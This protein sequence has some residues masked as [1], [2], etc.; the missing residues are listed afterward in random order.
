MLVAIKYCVPFTEVYSLWTR[1][2]ATIYK[3]GMN[4]M[5][6]LASLFVVVAG[7][8]CGQTVPPAPPNRAPDSVPKGASATVSTL[9]ASSQAPDLTFKPNPQDAPAPAPPAVETPP[10]APAAVPDAAETE[11]KPAADASSDKN[12]GNNSTPVTTQ[13]PKLVDM[14]P[15]VF[16][17]ND[18]ISV[19]VYNDNIVSGTYP[20][21]PD[22]RISMPLIH[23]FTVIGLTGPQL[24]QLITQKLSA[25][26]NE[27]VVNVQLLRNNSKKYTI[28]GGVGKP[29]A[30]PL[31]QET[32][33]LD[34]LAACGGFPEFSNKKDILIRRGT[35]EYHFNMKDALKGLHLDKN[36]PLQDGDVIVVKE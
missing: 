10:V 24:Q 27:P 5:S 13:L 2:L 31:I 7:L 4:P 35:K 16:G 20:I 23:D 19:S 34:A 26:Y 33:I 21:G 3:V 32:T 28:F 15:Y 36:I 12:S 22:G 11:P 25:L 17:A 6:K 29:G 8:S 1:S 30:Y 9:P 14:A 18:V